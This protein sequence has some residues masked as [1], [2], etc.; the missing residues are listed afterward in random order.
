[1][2]SN[3][4]PEQC[5]EESDRSSASS[6][7]L[8]ERSGLL[9]DALRELQNQAIDGLELSYIY[10][11]SM[12]VKGITLKVNNRSDVLFSVL[13]EGG[14]K[15]LVIPANPASC[16]QANIDYLCK[17]ALCRSQLYDIVLRENSRVQKRLLIFFNGPD[18]GR[19]LD[20]EHNELCRL[21]AAV[22]VEGSK[23][24]KAAAETYELRYTNEKHLLAINTLRNQLEE[25]KNQLEVRKNQLEESERA[26][27]VLEARIGSLKISITSY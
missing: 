7:F 23:Y 12:K 26:R 6:A 27:K 14:I 2:E 4:A 19:I 10:S 1:M 16:F 18:P 3:L 25:W 20:L 21:Q 13:A 15:R 24:V 11:K 9:S 8:S 22:W 5:V 17:A